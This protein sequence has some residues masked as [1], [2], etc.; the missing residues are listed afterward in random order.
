MKCHSARYRC[1]AQM[2]WG[3][4]LL[5]LLSPGKAGAWQAPATESQ[6]ASSM[7]RHYDAAVHS[8]SVGDTAQARLEYRSFLADALH[9]LAK[10]R[11]QIGEYPQA[12][13]LFEEALKL[14][15]GDPVLALDYAE[16][17]LVARDRQKAKSLAQGVLAS[18]S[19]NARAHLL[20]GRAYLGMNENRRAKKEFEKAV[21]LDPNFENGYALATADLALADKSGAERIFKEMLAGFGDTA[22][23]HM[24]IG[25]AYGNA[26]DPEEAIRE[27]KRTIAEDN[28]YPGAHYSLG[29]AYL[30]RSGD[31]NFPEAIAEFHKELAFHPDDYFSYSQLGY[32]AMT[33]HRLPEAVDDLTHASKLDPNNPDN[34]L[35]LGQIYAELGRDVEA[36]AALRS[37]IAVTSD[38]SVNHYQI[39]GAHYQLGRL[40]IQDGKIAEGKKEMQISEELLLQNKQLDK[41]NVNGKPIRSSP[42]ASASALPV[43]PKMEKAVNAFQMQVGPAIADSYNNLGVIAGIDKDYT[44][45]TGYFEQAFK[46]D[47]TMEGLDYNWGRAA[48]AGHLYPEALPP[49]TRYVQ[50]HPENVGARSMLGVTQYMVG[51]YDRAIQT[52]QPILPHVDAVPA[53]TFMY[54]KALVQTGHLQQG[55]ARLAGL[56]RTNPDSAALHREL[57]EA[58]RKNAQPKDEEREMEIYRTLQGKQTSSNQLNGKN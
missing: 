39:R 54:A 25:L 52:L 5:L 32:I 6:S 27:F 18:D 10:D 19:K 4:V 26:D 53:L 49:L 9:R 15:P 43:D 23:L 48:F 45:A 2:L 56:E 38:P 1:V 44:A 37:A 34:F 58:Y 41:A 16:A 28:K 29:A 11:S 46:W 7:Q 42:F 12:V 22:A 3:T 35:L 33:Q 20:L 51:D 13:P 50:G 31:T 24:Q 40:L 47:P 57:A 14:T 36:E 55:I 21:A 8:Q 17:S 30:L